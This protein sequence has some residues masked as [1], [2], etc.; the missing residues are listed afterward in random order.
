MTERT[1]P[2]HRWL[3]PFSW[4]YGGGVWL[5]N[6][7]FDWKILQSKSFDV[8]VICIGNLTVGGTGKTPHTE[9]LIRLLQQAGLNVAV[10][11]RGYKRK[12]KG[13]ILADA[14]SNA[15][16]IGDE[17]YQMKEKFSQARIA[18]DA[19]R[20][21]G[22]S[23]LLE[24]DNPRPDVILLDDAFQH[25]Y[26]QAGLN[27]LLTDY[28]RL[29]TEDSLLP[30]G[31][32]REPASGKTRAQII[33]VTKCPQD[34]KPIDFNITGKQLNLY[35][36]QQLYFTR[37]RYGMPVAVFPQAVAERPLSKVL[38]GE[39]HVL[40]VTGIASPQPLV[41]EVKLYAKSLRQFSFSD[42]HDFNEKDLRLIEKEFSQMEGCQRLI[43]T[44]EKDAARLKAHPALSEDLKPYIY[45]IPIEVEIL[46]NQQES[47]NQNIIGY[48][49]KNSRNS[50]LP[51][52]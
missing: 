19:D 40:L 33:I 46:L 7:L 11:S 26:V 1:V 8:P 42:H 50:S 39:E 34:I 13:Y 21:H 35:P 18:V 28:N 24:L 52:K 3:L 22:I 14:H 10:L 51:Q 44:T 6:K 36:F 12:S 9:Y 5:R 16:Q 2:I 43:I 29:F 49:R 45:A 17:P 20:R 23:Q 48:V 30:A 32:L 27:I 15:T 37:I 25:R 38:S 47:F 41:E 4:I 31:R